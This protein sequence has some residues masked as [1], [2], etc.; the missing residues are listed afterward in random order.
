MDVLFTPREVAQ[1]LN[2]SPRTVC[3]YAEQGVIRCHVYP[4][5]SIRIPAS[6]VREFLEKTEKKNG[7]SRDNRDSQ[8]SAK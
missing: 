7:D 3:R 5:G 8:D 4:G 1:T 6:A 2:C